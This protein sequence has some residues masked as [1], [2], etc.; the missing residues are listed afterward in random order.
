M[1]V[2]GLYKNI[3]KKK[4]DSLD[5]MSTYVNMFTGNNIQL[6]IDYLNNGIPVFDV[7]GVSIDPF[8][9]NTVI[10]GGPSLISDGYWIWRY[11]L[12]YFME[13]YNLGL[14]DE[15]IIHAASHTNKI[16]EEQA[17]DIVK[18]WEVILS[19]YEKAEN[20]DRNILTYK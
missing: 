12:A 5:E 2:I 7:M 11:D 10:S 8:D 20:G 6:I 14:P 3:D 19:E 16:S 1:K 4:N 15:F 17:L 13:K 9:S 18:N